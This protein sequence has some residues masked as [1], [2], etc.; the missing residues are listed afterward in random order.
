MFW[1]LFG[2]CFIGCIVLFIVGGASAM[3]RSAAI[4]CNGIRLNG[5]EHMMFDTGIVL[6]CICTMSL[7][8]A[9]VFDLVWNSNTT[10]RG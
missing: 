2:S 7:F 6:F 9:L 5:F 3:Y 4:S 8:L 1:K 10:S